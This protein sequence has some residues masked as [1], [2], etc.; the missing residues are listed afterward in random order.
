VGLTKRPAAPRNV[1]SFF[2]INLILHSN[3][4]AHPDPVISYVSQD[5]TPIISLQIA[6][7]QIAIWQSIGGSGRQNGLILALEGGMKSDIFF[8]PLSVWLYL[9]GRK[10]DW[11]LLTSPFQVR[12]VD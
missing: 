5:G 1:K 4:K 9:E 2:T 12:F 7:C 11:Q 3:K 10:K 6:N 8:F